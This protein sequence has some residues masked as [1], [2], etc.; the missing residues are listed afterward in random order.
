MNTLTITI[1]ILAPVITLL[2][3][4]YFRAVKANEL[5]NVSQARDYW[6]MQ[7]HHYCNLNEIKVEYI[8]ALESQNETV[9]N[10]LKGCS[11]LLAEAHTFMQDGAFMKLVPNK[12][13]HH[14]A[15]NNY[16]YIEGEINGNRE[17]GL[18]KLSDWSKAKERLLKNPE[19]KPL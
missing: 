3:G 10:E 14:A 19:D 5:D 18:F 11:G 1:G 8:A 12:D 2:I 6:R 4:R 15:N 17:A 9:L 16:L 7:S 13:K